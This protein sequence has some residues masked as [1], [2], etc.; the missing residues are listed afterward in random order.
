[1]LF[2]A[3]GQNNCGEYGLTIRDGENNRVLCGD[4]GPF[5]MLSSTNDIKFEM[6]TGP[7]GGGIVDCTAQAIPVTADHSEITTTTTTTPKP[8]K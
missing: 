3:T 6:H 1:M 5:S 2:K 7:R 8:Y 4:V